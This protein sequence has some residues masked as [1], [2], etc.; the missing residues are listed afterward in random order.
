VAEGTTDASLERTLE[1]G[2]LGGA[3]VY[4]RR[5]VTELAGMPLEYGMRLWRALGFPTPPDDAV[6][7]T[8]ADLVALH[9]VQELLRSELVD[10][11]M[12][13]HMARAVGQTMG[14]LASW[15]SDVWIQRLLDHPELLGEGGGVSEETVATAILAT[16]ELRPIFERLL[17]H[18]WRRQLA[19]DGI[20]ALTNTAASIADPV[21]GTAQLAVGFADVVS[22]TRLS[23]QMDGDTL[24]TFVNRFETGAT[25]IIA[26][27]GGR[28]VKTLGDEVLFVADDARAG[29]EIGLRIAERVDFDPKFPRVRVGLAHGEIIQRLGDV[30]GTPVNLAARLTSTAN[31]A[32]VLADGALIH[33]LGEDGDYDAVPLRPRPLQGLG[34]VRPWVLRRPARSTT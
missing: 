5:Q 22:F 29:A 15:L 12:V 1:E 18:G 13:L 11:D 17:L 20:R 9:E 19:A 14:R 32:T 7:F 31:P 28:V 2:L 16:R 34:R 24:A 30:F 3:L 4:N 6:A 27:L 25:E 21:G 23:R 10:E 8:D 26:D 33:L